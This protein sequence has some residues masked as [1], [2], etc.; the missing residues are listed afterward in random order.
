MISILGLLLF[1]IIF[2]VV[3]F[4]PITTLESQVPNYQGCSCGPTDS[5]CTRALQS[6]I[7]HAEDRDTIIPSTWGG[8]WVRDAY[9]AACGEGYIDCL[10]REAERNEGVILCTFSINKVS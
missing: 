4:F 2:S 10:H 5:V 1:V 3:G 6:C 7:D 9:I 8:D